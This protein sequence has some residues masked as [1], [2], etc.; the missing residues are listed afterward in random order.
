MLAVFTAAVFLAATLLFLVQPMAAKMIL[1]LLGGTPGVWNTCMLFFQASL[2]VGYAYAHGLG[3]VRRPWVQVVIHAAML[4]GGA[5][6]LPI[7]LPKSEAW[8][9][10]GEGSPALWTLM[11][12]LATAGGPF[13]VL[14]ASGPLLQRWFSRTDHRQARDPYFLYAASNA[15][16]MLALLGYPLLVEPA[17]GVRE[18][19]VWWSIGYGVLCVLFVAAGV[20]M[21]QRPGAVAEQTRAPAGALSWGTRARWVAL[22]A[23][24]SSL[25]LGATQYITLDVA[26]VPMFWV[27]PLAMYLLTFILAFGPGGAWLGRAAGWVLPLAVLVVAVAFF[28][29][30]RSPMWMLMAVHLVALLLG[31]MVCHGRLSAERPDPS[32]LTEFFLLLALGGMLGGVFNALLAPMLFTGIAEYPIALVAALL[33]RSPIGAGRAGGAAWVGDALVPARRAWLRGALDVGMPML[34]FLLFVGFQQGW[35]TAAKPGEWLAR[36]GPMLGSTLGSLTPAE[37]AAAV[38]WLLPVLLC[39]TVIHRR[40]RF[41]LCATALLCIPAIEFRA[42]RDLLLRERTFFGVHRVFRQSD[43]S[44]SWNQLWHGRIMHGQQYSQSPW[45][46]EPGSYYSRPGPVGDL[47]AAA[48]GQP[49]FRSAAFI[50][51]GTAT[52]AAYGQKGWAFTYYEIDPGVVAIAQDDTL[53]TYYSTSAAEM[54]VVLGDARLTLG[55][56]EPGAYGLILVDAFSSDAIPVH[57]ITREAVERFMSKVAPGGLLSFHITNRY[58]RLEPVLERIATELGLDARVRVD[59]DLGRDRTRV[60]HN[61]STWVALGR[62]GEDR[63]AMSVLEA[64]PK[65]RKLRPMMVKDDGGKERPVPMRTWT[66][67]YADVL[68]VFRWR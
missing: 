17:L 22:A 8:L 43:G 11:V 29:D 54:R 36:L 10:T 66:D 21:I 44:G 50:G 48:E 30:W 39:V 60:G 42:N 63:N 56:A 9:P 46:E 58:I 55:R 4:L 5:A 34:V 51:M 59:D 16:S 26:S 2:L 64:D 6:L 12:L 53:F 19:T 27:V 32:R 61:V 3:R 25:M 18:Q 35:L 28:Q 31:A 68:S 20:W 37:W 40:L 24:P 67:D 38:G 49:G 14:S 45:R 23:V 57:L 33:L 62:R 1:P 52:L 41:A 47:F 15:G 13:I 7:G 65:W